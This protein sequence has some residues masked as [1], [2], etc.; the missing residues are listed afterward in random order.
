MTTTSA[1]RLLTLL[2]FALAAAIIVGACWIPSAGAAVAARLPVATA[3]VPQ[4]VGEA[5]ATFTREE[6]VAALT[7]ALTAHFNLE[8]DLQIELLR[9]WSAPARAA[10]QWELSVVEFPA[11]ASPSMMLR[12]RLLADGQ[13]VLDTT[14]MLRAQLWCDAWVSRQPLAAGSA[15]DPASLEVRRVDRLRERDVL[16]ATVG[17]RSFVFARTVSPGRLLS[18]RDISRRPLVKKGDLVEVSAADGQLIVLMKAQAMESGAQGDTVS[19]RNPESRKIFAAQVVDE[20]RVQVR[21]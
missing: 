5:S 11:A 9:P 1:Q 13:S 21:F 15:F 16:P 8:G 14:V 20:N 4:A 10:S 7:R 19:V 2:L 6:A 12:C 18:W 3:A 17:D